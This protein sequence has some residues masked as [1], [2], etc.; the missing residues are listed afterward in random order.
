MYFECPLAAVSLWHRSDAHERA[1][2]D[3]GK[4]RLDHARDLR[5][6]GERHLELRAIACLDHIKRAV[7]TFDG[8]AYTNRVLR[9]SRCDTGCHHRDSAQSDSRKRSYRHVVFGFHKFLPLVGGRRCAT[10]DA[11]PTLRPPAHA[12][13]GSIPTRSVKSWSVASVPRCP[14]RSCLPFGGSRF[15]APH[16][17][18]CPIVQHHWKRAIVAVRG[19]TGTS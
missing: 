14:Q 18:S 1:L 2:L 9:H 4:R 19:R 16:P 12:P 7:D 17:K 8:A 15:A 6:V 5:V 11:R 13:R 3:V 10:R